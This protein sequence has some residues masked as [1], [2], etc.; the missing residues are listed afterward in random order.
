MTHPSTRPM[1]LANF[2]AWSEVHWYTRAGGKTPEGCR[3]G[4]IR[5][6][7]IVRSWFAPNCQSLTLCSGKSV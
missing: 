1:S 4:P 7:S 2:R 6:M 5:S 3:S